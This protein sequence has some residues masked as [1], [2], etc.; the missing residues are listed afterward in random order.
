MIR[1]VERKFGRIIED[2]DSDNSF[3]AKIK[4]VGGKYRSYGEKLQQKAP[5]ILL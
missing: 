3:E 1:D 4:N 5:P 2:N